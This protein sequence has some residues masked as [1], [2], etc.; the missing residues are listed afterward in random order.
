MNISDKEEIG[1]LRFKLEKLQR[2]YNDL[3]DS[4]TKQKM[5]NK[6]ELALNHDLKQVIETMKLQSN[7]LLEIIEHYSKK[8][9]K[10]RNNIDILINK[11]D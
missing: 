8:I 5:I 6:S 11:N 3:Q 4:L 7:S 1:K 10:Y 9:I 2:E